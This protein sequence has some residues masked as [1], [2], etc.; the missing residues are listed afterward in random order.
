MEHRR[1]LLPRCATLTALG[2]A[3]LAAGC[4]EP[5]PVDDRDGLLRLELSEYALRPQVVKT[6]A[7]A[8]RIRATNAGRL[9]H[10]VAIQEEPEGEGA[11]REARVLGSTPTAQPGRTVR[12][13]TAIRLAPG[14]YRM[15]CTL[16]NH[17]TLGE[18]GTLIVTR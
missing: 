3:A 1:S 8:I 10:N 4:G 5:D 15:A 2:A 12:T 7:S 16:A 13:A 9:P 17:D 6:S 11:E 14:R 18:Y